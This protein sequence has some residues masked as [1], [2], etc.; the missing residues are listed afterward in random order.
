MNDQYRGQKQLINLSRKYNFG[1][2]VYDPERKK[3]SKAAD[4]LSGSMRRGLKTV[5]WNLI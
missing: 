2:I 3:I 1:A 4:I 5:Q